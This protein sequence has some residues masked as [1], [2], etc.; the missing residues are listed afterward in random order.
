MAGTE[1][2][3]FGPA[4][5]VVVN[6]AIAAAVFPIIFIGELPDKTMFA[7]LVLATRG[8]P[9]AVWLGAAGA[10]M[11]HVV[12]ATTIG[13][14]LFHL[15]PHRLLDGIVALLFLAGAGLA[16]REATKTGEEEAIIEKE[17]ASGRRVVT[18]AFIVI[19]L[20]EW[21]DLTQILTANLAAHYHSPVSVGVGAV[22][23]LWAV[24][25]LAVIGG[26]SILRF[27]NIKTLRI[28][29]AVALIAL[30]GWSGWQ[31]LR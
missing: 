24:A 19:F 15:V 21:G 30:A 10:F 28:I 13:V 3:P 14:A 8:R 2:N 5:E 26:Q 23:A 18:T 6:F 27:V 9:L 22:L 17:V 7:S 29:T 31:A 12:I 11:V 16:I 4:G 1:A 20:A 25:G